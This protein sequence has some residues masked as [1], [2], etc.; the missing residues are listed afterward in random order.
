MNLLDSGDKED[1]LADS[2][3][4]SSVGFYRL[5]NNIFYKMNIDD[6]VFQRRF[7]MQLFKY[8]SYM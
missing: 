6:D 3:N 5:T 8:I 2:T 7:S 1:P 4:T